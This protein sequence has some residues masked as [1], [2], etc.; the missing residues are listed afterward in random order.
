MLGDHF[1]ITLG[2]VW[3]HLGIVLVGI[4][5]I[6]VS[7]VGVGVCYNRNYSGSKLANVGTYVVSSTIC[8]RESAPQGLGRV[9]FREFVPGS[10]S[11]HVVRRMLAPRSS[12]Q[13][14]TP[15]GF[16]T[17]AS[18]NVGTLRPGELRTCRIAERSGVTAR[19]KELDVMF[20]SSRLDVLG[21][22]DGTLQ[23]S[24]EIALQLYA[25]FSAS[26]DARGCDGSQTWV[27]RCLK[28]YYTSANQVSPRILCVTL[29]FD[30]IRHY[31]ISAHTPIGDA[32]KKK[33]G[34]LVRHR[35]CDCRASIP[36]WSQNWLE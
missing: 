36:F 18:T 27:K 25:V 1:G 22:R 20:N 32:E 12:L 8:P 10:S 4:N 16:T 15:P 29:A 9:S 23:V 7:S 3:L 28:R 17:V 24:G 26:A 6:N 19:M 30:S 2:S 33:G 31:F 34:V 14:I 11:H 35:P 21:I 13:C 5:H